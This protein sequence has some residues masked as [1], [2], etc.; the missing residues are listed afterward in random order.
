MRPS[1]QELVSTLDPLQTWNWSMIFGT[2]PGSSDTRQMTY[3][4]VSTVI[5]GSNLEQVGLEAHGLKLNFA[6]RRT[7]SGQWEATFFETRDAGTRTALVNWQEF[8][9]S[10]VNNSGSYKSEYATKA[11]LQLF[12]DRPLVVREIEIYGVYPMTVGEPQ[13]DQTSDI[14]RY[15][16]TFSFD[17]TKDL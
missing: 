5:P 10:W 6:G 1:L 2:I 9:R 11:A 12:D 7:W 17:Y 8:S 4:C 13:L 16:V 3:K 15:P 14:I